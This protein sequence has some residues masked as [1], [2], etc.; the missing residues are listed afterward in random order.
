[1]DLGYYS[2]LPLISNILKVNLSV[3]HFLP[4]AHDAGGWVDIE[5]EGVY[6]AAD[7]TA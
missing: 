6:D 5:K 1:M 3:K 7:E 2:V 4:M